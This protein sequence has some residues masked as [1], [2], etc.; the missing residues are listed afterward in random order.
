MRL[1]QLAAVLDEIKALWNLQSLPTKMVTCQTS[2][3]SLFSFIQISI[4]YP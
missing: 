2:V 3:I 1:I 4:W